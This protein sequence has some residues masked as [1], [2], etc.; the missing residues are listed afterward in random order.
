[1]ITKENFDAMRMELSIKAKNGIDFIIAASIMWLIITYVWTL[2]Y[3]PYSKSVLTFIVG[4]LM[5]PLAYLISKILKTSWSNKDNP[6]QP[7]GL[8]LNFAQLFYFP[9]LIFTLIKMP[10]Y[11]VMVY[12]VITGAHFFPYA[13]YY[14]ISL[15]AVFA[16]IISLGAFV[17]ALLLPG[18]K[19]YY[20]PLFMSANLIV[21]SI[22]LHAN[23]RK[24]TPS[25]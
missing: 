20:I 21:L 7:L 9:F 24:R 6:L 5:L 4:G 15:Y 8:W 1:M 14:K 10:E 18:D 25:K 12:V 13:W 22:L 11:F 19:L 2:P 17:L 23:V 3:T 16:G